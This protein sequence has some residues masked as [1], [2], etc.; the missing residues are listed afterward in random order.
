MPK[1]NTGSSSAASSS[2]TAGWI[3]VAGETRYLQEGKAVIF[4]DSFLH[5]AGNTSAEEP[6]V[7]LIVDIWHPDLSDEEVM[8]LVVVG[9]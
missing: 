5:E 6:R 7:V 1:D 8:D 9:V 2:G 4:D 3:K